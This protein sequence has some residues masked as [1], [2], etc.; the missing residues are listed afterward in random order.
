MTARRL[1]HYY[2][3]S[4]PC[5]RKEGDGGAIHVPRTVPV[6]SPRERRAEQSKPLVSPRVGRQSESSLDA[7]TPRPIRLGRLNSKG[8]H[9][10]GH[11]VFAVGGGEAVLTD[12][13]VTT[14]GSG[15]EGERGGDGGGSRSRARIRAFTTGADG[16]CNIDTYGGAYFGSPPLW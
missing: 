6:G 12:R 8:S 10:M 16:R 3:K 13:V 14:E 11:V 4:I 9:R 5:F 2:E 1:S 15:V 7:N